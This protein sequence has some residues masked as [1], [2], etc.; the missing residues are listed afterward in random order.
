MWKLDSTRR[1]GL[2]VATLVTLPIVLC[3][4]VLIVP[5]NSLEGV[6]RDI[7]DAFDDAIELVTDNIEGIFDTAEEIRE[8]LQ[9]AAE[10]NE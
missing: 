8:D 10:R 4:A 9:E 1:T 3:V 5:A 7:R 2:V 6:S